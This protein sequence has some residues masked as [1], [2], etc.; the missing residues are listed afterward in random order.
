[1]VQSSRGLPAFGGR[2]S[3]PEADKYQGGR[4]VPRLRDDPSNPIFFVGLKPAIRLRRIEGF[5]PSAQSRRKSR[6]AKK[7]F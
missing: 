7:L 4:D 1:L 3:P 5:E 6:E 2:T